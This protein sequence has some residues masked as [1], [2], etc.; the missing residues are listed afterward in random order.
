M[1]SDSSRLAETFPRLDD[2]PSD[3]CARPAPDVRSMPARCS[4]SRV[5]RRPFFFVIEARRR[6][7]ILRGT[8]DHLIRTVHEP[9]GFKHRDITVLAGFRALVLRRAR[10]AGRVVELDRAGAARRRRVRRQNHKRD[11]MRASSSRTGLIEGGYGHVVV[12][13]HA[14]GRTPPRARVSSPSTANPYTAIDGRARSKTKKKRR[15]RRSRLSSASA[16]RTLPS[17]LPRPRVLKNPESNRSSPTA[18]VYTAALDSTRIRDL[19]VVG[20]GPRAFR[21]VSGH[22]RAST[23]SGSNRS[24]GARPVLAFPIENTSASLPVISGKPS[25]RVRITRRRSA[26]GT[27]RSRAPLHAW[28][29]IAGPIPPHRAWC[30]EFGP[31]RVPSDRHRRALSQASARSAGAISKYLGST[32]APR[33]SRSRLCGCE[34]VLV[35]GGAPRRSGG[36]VPRA[37]RAK[38]MSLARA[39]AVTDQSR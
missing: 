34:E 13:A 12:L 21:A 25:P 9:G 22:R 10:T 29:V 4:S 37:H 1:T 2:A 18:S 17:Y 16:S 3:A 32:T 8:G 7:P 39:R 5:K 11:V 23:F 6:W 35:V 15:R 31:P 14:L 28:P 20:A 33:R 19:G 30:T 26:S 36:G 24:P 27:S 38:V